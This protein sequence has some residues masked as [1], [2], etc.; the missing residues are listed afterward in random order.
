M[1][2]CCVLSQIIRLSRGDM[3]NAE[4]AAAILVTAVIAKQGRTD[5]DDVVAT[6]RNVLAKLRELPDDASSGRPRKRRAPPVDE[7]TRINRLSSALK[8]M[9]RIERQEKKAH[10]EKAPPE[11]G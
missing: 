8:R 6:Y 2:L 4:I 10:K 9:D 1:P 11:R 7:E 5:V 3:E